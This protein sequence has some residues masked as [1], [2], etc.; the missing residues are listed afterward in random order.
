MTWSALEPQHYTEP[1]VLERERELI[2]DAQ[3]VPVGLVSDLQADRDFIAAEVAGRG[4]VV[5]NF[6]GELRAFE[7]VCSHRQS[8]LRTCGRGN[9][10]LRC[11]YHGWTFDSAGVPVGIPQRRSFGDMSPSLLQQLTL[12]RWALEVVGPLVFVA[13]KPRESSL[14]SSMGSLASELT[15][16]L[17]GARRCLDRSVFEL[18]CNWKVMLENGL[19]AYHVP[20]VHA[21]TIHKHGLDEL[22]REQ[23]G[24]HSV[25]R[26]AAASSARVLRA[27]RY[28]YPEA[29]LSERYTHFLLYPN[30]YV[31]SV[32]GLFVVVSRIDPI[33]ASTT[34]FESSVFVSWD[35]EQGNVT[36]REEVNASN[37]AFF[38]NGYQEDKLI[39]EQV[40]RALRYT[41]R[42]ALLG[43]EEE[44]IAMFHQSWLRD[45]GRA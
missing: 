25:G 11:P 3:W 33:D 43:T 14:R 21:Q 38:R 2:F 27:L 26:F 28:A 24:E 36:L 7:N 34:R 19:D 30:T 22:A 16:V 23:H 20:L 1:S 45:L 39:C 15:D 31:V 17:Q 37:A 35:G 13:R 32:Y 8:P 40:Q 9:G 44:R 10:P 18:G 42:K 5:Q 41:E 29:S 12:D 4:V 6:A